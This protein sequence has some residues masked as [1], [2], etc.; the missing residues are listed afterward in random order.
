V[1]PTNDK[2]LEVDGAKDEEGQAVKVA[3][4]KCMKLAT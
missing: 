2:V 3:T 4:S 1:N